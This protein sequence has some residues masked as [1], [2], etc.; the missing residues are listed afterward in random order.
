MIGLAAPP[1]ILAVR[2]RLHLIAAAIE[3]ILNRVVLAGPPL[4]ELLVNDPA[5]RVPPLTFAADAVLQL[6][7]TSM[8]DR[9][10]SDLQKLGMTRV[11]RSA[12]GDRWRISDDVSFDLIQVR[13]DDGD[14]DQVWLEY[15]TLLTL[16]LAVDQRLSVRITGAPAMLAIECAAFARIGTS[17]LESE[18]FERIVQLIAGR[19]EIEQECAAAPPELRAVIGSSLSRAARDDSVHLAIQR[20]LPDAVLLPSLVKRVQ[21]RILRIAC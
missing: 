5:V 11:G 7:S 8:I 4:V 21:A 15:A 12:N 13:A 19:M 20:V 16:P 18:E 1:E 6:L 3:P 2:T 10:G 17:L 14:G 9:L